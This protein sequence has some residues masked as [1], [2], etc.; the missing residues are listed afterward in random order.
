MSFSPRATRSHARLNV[1]NPSTSKFKE[2]HVYLSL[3][4]IGKLL[5]RINSQPSTEEKVVYTFTRLQI[6]H[7]LAGIE[8]E[9][10]F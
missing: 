8:T 1:N 4:W 3:L 9:L 5:K 10:H 7:E 6:R 2:D